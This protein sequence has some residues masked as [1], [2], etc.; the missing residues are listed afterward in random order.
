[1]SFGQIEDQLRQLR[2]VTK[3]N[4]HSATTECDL[5]TF[6]ALTGPWKRKFSL[7]FELEGSYHCVCSEEIMSR[8]EG[9]RKDID[10][11]RKFQGQNEADDPN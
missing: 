7:D 8:I 10:E 11:I 9:L 2:H 5:P 6:E 3:E 4:E 1:M